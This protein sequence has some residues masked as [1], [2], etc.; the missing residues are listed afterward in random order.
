MHRA[1]IV[2]HPCV[3]EE[4]C[5]LT[6][7]E[8]MASGRPVIASNLGGIPEQIDDGESGL[9]G[10]RGRPPAALPGHPE[11]HR[12]PRF[13]RQ[14]LGEGARAKALRKFDLGRWVREHVEYCEEAAGRRATPHRPVPTVP[15]RPQGRRLRV[16]AL[17]DFAPRKLGSLEEWTLAF[18]QEMHRRGH[19]VDV[20]AH[21]PVHPAIAEGLIRCGAGWGTLDELAAHPRRA[22]RQL[23]QYDLL[24]LTL[25]GLQTPLAYLAYAAWPA[26]IGLL[27]Q[28]SGPLPGG[29][30]RLSEIRSRIM[31]APARFRVVGVAGVTEYVTRRDRRLYLLPARRL[32][33]IYN[34]VNLSRFQPRPPDNRDGPEVRVL[35]V[36]NLHWIKGV[37][38]LVEAAA[39]LQDLPIWVTIG[40]DGEELDRLRTLARAGGI[41]D[42]VEFLGLRNDVDQ[43]L[44]E[45]DIFVHPCVWEEAFGLSI[46][47]A[48][49]SGLAVV[50]SGLGGIPELI[51]DGVTGLLVPPGDP[52]RLAD[53]IRRLAC[54]ADLRTRLG[55]AAR[56]RAEQLFDL[57]QCV[58]RHAD[59][60]ERLTSS[61][62]AGTPALDGE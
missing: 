46:A 10:A 53:A 50:A 15:T 9:L 3:W 61:D 41:A 51:E 19:H 38:F 16:A 14:R 4:A 22:I 57:A 39:L 28:L 23:R 35:T 29:I 40:G 30:T 36:A 8:A 60:I 47:E 42:R 20:F 44:H 5:A 43:L 11:A 25:I 48:M 49:A 27:D 34:G 52:V 32:C 55:A 13:L 33:T 24:Y 58:A 26:P 18:A 21:D 59:Y 17:L 31:S 7:M 37:N 56:H 6:I 62:R 1:D 45:A 54:D 12:R 2:V